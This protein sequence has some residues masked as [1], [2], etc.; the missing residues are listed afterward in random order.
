MA[1]SVVDF[2]IT[3]LACFLVVPSARTLAAVSSKGGIFEDLLVGCKALRK[4]F[5]VLYF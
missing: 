1:P 2:E 4:P 3:L 5:Q